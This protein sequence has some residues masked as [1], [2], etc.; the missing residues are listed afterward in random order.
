MDNQDQNKKNNQK[1]DEPDRKRQIFPLIFIAIAVT[2][3]INLVAT[4]VSKSHQE[5]KSF[6]ELNDLLEGGKID[7]AEFDSDRIFFLTK[8]EAAKEA[9]DQIIYYTGMIPNL[10][11]A[12][13]LIKVL[14]EERTRR[15]LPI[16]CDPIMLSTSGT[17]KPSCSLMQRNSAAVS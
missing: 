10:E 12:R 6:S 4:A 8:E 14:R 7:S 16:V 11:V 2:L 3:V 17:Q 9:K 1:K 15:T 13:I 5:E